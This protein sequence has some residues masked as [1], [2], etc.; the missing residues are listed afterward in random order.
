MAS[1]A[2]KYVHQAAATN[3]YLLCCINPSVTFSRIFF[4]PFLGSLGIVVAT[5]WPSPPAWHRSIALQ[6]ALSLGHAAG[7]AVR[8]HLYIALINVCPGASFSSPLW[9]PSSS[10]SSPPGPSTCW[11]RQRIR[12]KTWRTRRTSRRA[13]AQLNRRIKVEDFCSFFTTGCS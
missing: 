3:L 13:S 8:Y 4:C 2:F 5:T 12:P 9:P 7:T 10:P 11:S 6:A 1:A